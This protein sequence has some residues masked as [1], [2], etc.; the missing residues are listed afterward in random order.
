MKHILAFCLIVL[1]ALPAMA[2]PSEMNLYLSYWP[3]GAEDAQGALNLDTQEDRIERAVY[4]K[5]GAETITYLPLTPEAA[6]TIEAGIRAAIAGISFD[7]GEE[8]TEAV[9]RV[10]WSVL[11]ASSFARGTLSFPMESQPEALLAVQDA[12]FGM[13]LG[14][15]QP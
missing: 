14:P 12:L 9:L 2:E 15:V 7:Y 11:T 4:D 5:D 8:L 1:G 13:R 6:L 3:E 10:E